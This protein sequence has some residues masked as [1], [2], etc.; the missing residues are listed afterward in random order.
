[1]S[2]RVNVTSLLV[3]GLTPV[4]CLATGFS[5][6]VSHCRKS[7][8]LNADP[9]FVRPYPM[10][11]SINACSVMA[12]ILVSGPRFSQLSL[13]SIVKRT[14][15]FFCTSSIWLREGQ[16]SSSRRPSKRKSSFASNRSLGELFSCSTCPSSPSCLAFRAVARSL[17]LFWRHREGPAR[18]L[19]RLIC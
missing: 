2:A 19:G 17:S 1:M 16:C 10:T 5:T 7:F 12:R 15:V 3:A 9:V 13:L 8:L 18:R 11:L 4:I 14:P 6:R